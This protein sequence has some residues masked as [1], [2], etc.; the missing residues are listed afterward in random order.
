MVGIN[1]DGYDQIRFVATHSSNGRVD[2]QQR[3]W[4]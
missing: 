2:D 3:Y 1:G 4:A